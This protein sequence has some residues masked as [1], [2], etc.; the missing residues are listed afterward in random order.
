MSSALIVQNKGGGHGELGYQ[1]AKNLKSNPAITSIT[2]LQDD[3][4]NDKKEPFKSYESDLPDVRVV[5]APLGDES[6][7]AEKLQEILGK[8]ESYDYVWDNASKGPV[9]AGKAVCDCAK[10]WNTKLFTYV[11]SAG[12]YKPSKDTTFP[13][14]ETTPIKE[15]AGQNLFDRYAVEIGLPLVSFRPQYIYGKKSNKFDYLDWYFDRIVRGLPLPIPGDGKQKVSLTNSE[16]VASLLAS[17]LNDPEAAVSQ[18]FFNCGTD[19]LIS[20]DDVAYMCADAA[21]KSRD[22]VKIEHYDAE[23]LGKGHFPFRVTDFYVA[24][25]M[26]KDKLHWDGSKNSL[27]DDLT[28]YYK[29]YLERGGPEKK[30]D[31]GKDREIVVGHKS[32]WSVATI[33]DKY[34]PL[35]IDTS[36]TK[37][38]I[39]EEKE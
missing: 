2:I 28:W 37:P 12:M 5:K 30:I 20:Y 22:D 24:P 9:G 18:R 14:A 21:G 19:H 29:G 23:F 4:C 38:L 15:S 36:Q 10:Q 34:D 31:L 26:A 11:S 16:D 7:S 17:V 39:F 13:M 35:I 27:K 33:Y 1:L 25:D 32:T 3:A 8:G 6:M